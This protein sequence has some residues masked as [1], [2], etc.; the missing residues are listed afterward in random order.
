MKIAND[1]NE[2]YSQVGPKLASEI[3]HTNVNFESY[4]N[5]RID[6]NFEFHRISEIDILKMV[7]QLK[8]KV[9]AGADFLLL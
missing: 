2:F 9:S 5:D 8:P 6:S 1:F 4:L 7:K 3:N